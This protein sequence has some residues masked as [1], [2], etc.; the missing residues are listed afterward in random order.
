MKH[1]FVNVLLIN[2]SKTKQ[3]KG[4]NINKQIIASTTN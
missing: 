1:I 3:K 4:K 2:D